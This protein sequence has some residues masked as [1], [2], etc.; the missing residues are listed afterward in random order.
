MVARLGSERI[1]KGLTRDWTLKVKAK[2]FQLAGSQAPQ[3][4][5]F[6]EMMSLVSREVVAWLFAFLKC[7]CRGIVILSGITGLK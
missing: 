4:A 1:V 3:P 2:C 5:L 6:L 7:I